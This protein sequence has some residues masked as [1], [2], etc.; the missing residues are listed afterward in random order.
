MKLCRPKTETFWCWG[1]SW[2]SEKSRNPNLNPNPNPVYESA[3]S[4]IELLPDSST[5]P[6]PQGLKK[7]RH[8]HPM[9]SLTRH[10]LSLGLGSTGLLNKWPSITSPKGQRKLHGYLFSQNNYTLSL[11]FILFI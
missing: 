4:M 2:T 7:L 5:V 9:N 11:F 3:P 10:C 8:S 6:Q 1:D